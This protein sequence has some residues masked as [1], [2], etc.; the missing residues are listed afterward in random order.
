MT[1]PLR[2]INT[3]HVPAMRAP[4]RHSTVV[5]SVKLAGSNGER[6]DAIGIG[7]S[8]ADALDWALESAPAGVAWL[9]S[10]WSETYG[11]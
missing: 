11:D 8:E 2:V 10:S 1:Q 5:L 3:D 4:D 6:W 9:V 7:C